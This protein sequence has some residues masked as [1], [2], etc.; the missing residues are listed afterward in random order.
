MGVEV[1]HTIYVKNSAEAVLLYQKTF[2]LELGYH[3]KNSDGSY[4]HSELYSDGHPVLC[5]AESKEAASEN[6]IVCLGLTL[7]SEQAVRRAYE[8]LCSDGRVKLE[9]TSLPWSPCCAEVVDRF[10]VWWYITAPQHRPPD[11]FTPEE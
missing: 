11:D 9:L 4:Y 6:N 10:G 2:G 5:V 7:E 8:L 1:G 3:V